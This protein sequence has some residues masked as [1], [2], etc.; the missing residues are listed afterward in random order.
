MIHPHTFCLPAGRLPDCYI[1]RGHN[2]DFRKFAALRTRSTPT[3]QLL[4]E[5]LLLTFGYDTLVD[6]TE[7]HEEL[8][9]ALL[10]RP[11]LITLMFCFQLFNSTFDY[12]NV[13]NLFELLVSYHNI[14][15]RIDTKKSH[16]HL[17]SIII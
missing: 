12:S 1:I 13:D 10:M 17:A 4:K 8:L 3:I 16:F 5:T 6:L 14:I 2:P 15:E 11:K 7:T 9:Y